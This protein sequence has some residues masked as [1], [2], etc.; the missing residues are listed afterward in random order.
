MRYVLLLRGINVGGNNRVVIKE[1][2]EQLTKVGFQHIKVN[3][4]IPIC[5][6]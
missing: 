6:S 5:L 1:L 3:L 4:K 2:K